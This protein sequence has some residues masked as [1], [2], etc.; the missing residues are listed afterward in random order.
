M[1]RGE[2]LLEHHLRMLRNDLIVE[3]FGVEGLRCRANLAPSSRSRPDSNV[4]FQVKVRKPFKVYSLSWEAA[5]S[6]GLED[7]LC[8]RGL[9]LGV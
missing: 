3:G 4:G 8:N 7:K 9:G 1:V 5:T 2:F 6:E